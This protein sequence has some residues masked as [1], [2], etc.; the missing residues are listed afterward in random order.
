MRSAGWVVLAAC[1]T[2]PKPTPEVP[3]I[4]TP[5]VIVEQAAPP[6]DAIRAFVV[7]VDAGRFDQ[8][9]AMLSKSWR[10]RYSA[11]R[12]A[13]DFAIDPIA[14]IR[15]ERIRARLGDAVVIDGSRASLT[16]AE[17]RSVRLEREDDRWTISALE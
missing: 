12:F 4:E 2:A 3:V 10:A 17:G 1:V 13:S 9:V 11:E 7:A 15:L 6:R 14:R 5:P 16:W 8:A